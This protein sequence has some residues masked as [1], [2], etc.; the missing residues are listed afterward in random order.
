MRCSILLQIFSFSYGIFAGLRGY[1]FSLLSTRLMEQLRYDV[2]Q[3]DCACNLCPFTFAVMRPL[4]C[5]DHFVN[6]RH[7]TMHM[8]R[9]WLGVFNIDVGLV[10]PK[11]QVAKM[12][13]SRSI[14]TGCESQICQTTRKLHTLLLAQMT[15]RI[16]LDT[17]AICVKNRRQHAKLLYTSVVHLTCWLLAQECACGR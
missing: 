15:A 9:P 5:K 16:S 12:T 4:A 11:F 1:L 7:V 13:Y 14:V 17:L 8:T 3:I 6:E 2:C 10:H